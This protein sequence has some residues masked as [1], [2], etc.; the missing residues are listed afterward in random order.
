MS[1]LVAKP[2]LG[3]ARRGFDSLEDETRVDRLPVRGELPRW[4]QGSLLR[5]GPAKWEVGG[6]AMRHWF[7]GFA[8]LHRFS[9]LPFARL[10]DLMVSYA[11]P[12]GGVGPHKDSYDVFLLQ[13]LGKRRW[14]IERRPDPTCVP[15][16][17]IQQL[18]RFRPQRLRPVPRPAMVR[19]CRMRSCCRS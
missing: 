5:T 7:D 1:T 2:V 17:P 16:L 9:F 13:A 18:A 19:G 3:S 8:M 6:R 12:G 14:R 11:A 10:D 4:L 15:G